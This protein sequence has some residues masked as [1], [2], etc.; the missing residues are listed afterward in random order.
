MHEGENSLRNHYKS[1][2]STSNRTRN[3]TCSRV[4]Q[5]LLPKPPSLSNLSKIIKGVSELLPSLD[6]EDATLDTLARKDKLPRMTRVSRAFS[7]VFS[8]LSPRRSMTP[9]AGRNARRTWRNVTVST[10]SDGLGDEDCVA[11][12]GMRGGVMRS[13]RSGGRAETV[14][15]VR[16]W[17]DV[18]KHALR[19]SIRPSGS[20]I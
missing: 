7:L 3:L 1:E 17:L 6:F 9:P 18:R 5:T 11:D 8:R 12:A 15:A 16:C 2:K 13:G 14:A 19:A 10:A 4:L 20:L